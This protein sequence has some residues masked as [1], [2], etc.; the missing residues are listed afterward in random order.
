VINHSERLATALADVLDFIDTYVAEMR[1]HHGYDLS[2]DWSGHLWNADAVLDAYEKSRLK[3][4]G[5]DA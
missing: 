3:V 4:G 2:E 5:D 1:D